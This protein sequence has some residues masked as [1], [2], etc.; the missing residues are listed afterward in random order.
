MDNFKK[1]STG[2]VN[3][4]NIYTY[5]SLYIIRGTPFKAECEE[6]TKARYGKTNCKN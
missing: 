4:T 1:T 6:R 5:I 2:T 3:V